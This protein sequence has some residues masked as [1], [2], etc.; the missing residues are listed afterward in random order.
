MR[1]REDGDGAEKGRIALDMRRL[2]LISCFALIVA[3][4]LAG[5]VFIRS[6]GADENQDIFTNLEQMQQLDTTMSLNTF[7]KAIN[8]AGFSATLRG[9]G[10]YTVFAPTDDAFDKLGPKTSLINP[11]GVAGQIQKVVLNHVVNG[12]WTM[13][14]L[15]K[16]RRC[17]TLTGG[18]LAFEDLRGQPTIGNAKIL[19]S[20]PAKNG[21]IYVIDTVL[22]PI[23]M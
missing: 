21:M 10:M 23:G 9:P 5:G 8:A 20:V 16:A 3:G 2:V 15:V 14:D 4:P 13:A 11:S 18:S 17:T 22:I 1:G 12:V 7:V 6:A 19:R